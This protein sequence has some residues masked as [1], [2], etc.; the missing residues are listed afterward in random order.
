[1]SNKY[2]KDDEYSLI[3]FEDVFFL[4]LHRNNSLKEWIKSFKNLYYEKLGKQLLL[5]FH[6][7]DALSSA[8]L[9]MHSGFWSC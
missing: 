4:F 2:E 3:S 5:R 6:M 7:H 8:V 9:A 1:M